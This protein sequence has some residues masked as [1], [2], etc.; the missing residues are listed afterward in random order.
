MTK[1]TRTVEVVTT[2]LEILEPGQLRASPETVL[3][4]MEAKIPLPELNRFLY[5]AVGG[6]WNWTDRLS[7]TYDRWKSYLDRDELRTF[8][9]YYQGTPAGYYELEQQGTDVEIRSFG[10]LG[11]F[12]GQGLGGDLLTRA[13]RQAWSIGAARVW[14]H[15]CD[16]DSPAGL[17]NYLSRGFQVYRTERSH[18]Q[19]PADPPGPWPGSGR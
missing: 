6:D 19:I 11:Q 10:L 4:V 14:L 9:G 5:T 3:T 13:V 1:Q 17:Q 12:I 15:T 18:Q 16:L 8:V 2:Y 7:W